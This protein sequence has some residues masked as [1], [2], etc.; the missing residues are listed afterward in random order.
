MSQEGTNPT[1]N[2][3]LIN[4]LQQ[5]RAENVSFGG[6]GGGERKRKD[7]ISSGRYVNEVIIQKEQQPGLS[8]KFNNLAKSSNDESRDEEDDGTTCEFCEIS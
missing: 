6:G 2:K 5:N 1:F 7:D 4:L 8:G 3:T